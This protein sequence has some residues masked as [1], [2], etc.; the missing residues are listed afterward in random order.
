LL[1]RF[2]A[3]RQRDVFA[4]GRATRLIERR[5]DPV[6]DEGEGRPALKRE[7]LPHMMS[8]HEHRVM[9]RWI[10]PPPSHPRTLSIPRSRLSTEHVP[11][12][13]LRADVLDRLVDD[14]M[15]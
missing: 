11:A 7:R 5:L 8:K 9:V 2:R 6:G 10:A 4:I 13:P 12:H 15:R 3:P 14:A 1:R